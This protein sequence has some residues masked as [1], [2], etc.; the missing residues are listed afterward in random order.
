[1]KKPIF[2]TKL[3]N[4]IGKLI[5]TAQDRCSYLIKK[6]QQV[7]YG[8]DQKNSFWNNQKK[9]LDKTLD[10]VEHKITKLK[11]ELKNIMSAS[12]TIIE[13]FRSKVKNDQLDKLSHKIDK[14]PFDQLLTEKRLRYIIKK[15][16]EST[17]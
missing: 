12:H 7:D 6:D 13:E 10:S 9:E 14:K 4:E 17:N 8:F 15:E 5:F 1:M 11:F 2:D 3:N 16:L